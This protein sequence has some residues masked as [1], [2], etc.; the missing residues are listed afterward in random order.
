[1]DRHHA[2]FLLDA[3]MLM[4]EALLLMSLLRHA[5]TS[6][7]DKDHA[8]YAAKAPHIS[9]RLLLKQ[10][11][12]VLPSLAFVWGHPATLLIFSFDQGVVKSAAM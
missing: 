8:D 4:Q 6:M 5:A 7:W 1:M 10:R 11:I 3:G 9:Y 2:P 12:L